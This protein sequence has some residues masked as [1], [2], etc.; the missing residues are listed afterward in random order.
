[1]TINVIKAQPRYRQMQAWDMRQTSWRELGSLIQ[2][3]GITSIRNLTIIWTM[4]TI[5]STTSIP[6]LTT[7]SLTTTSSVMSPLSF[8]LMIFHFVAIFSKSSTDNTP[9]HTFYGLICNKATRIVVCLG[10]QLSSAGCAVDSNGPQ[11]AVF[12]KK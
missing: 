4:T 3:N 10:D 7:H 1:M 2:S 9:L 6:T 11:L 12:L 8:V 5:T